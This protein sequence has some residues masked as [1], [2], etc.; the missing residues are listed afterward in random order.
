MK[1]L[2]LVLD[3]LADISHPELGWRTPLQA[4]ETPC[5][6][7]LA[8]EGCSA[9]MY[10]L[11]PGICPSSEVAHWAMFGYKPEEF[12]GRAYFHALAAGLPFATG[13]ALYMFNLVRVERRK[14]GTY[15]IDGEESSLAEACEALADELCGAAPEGL[16]V[17]YMGGIEF[18]AVVRGG[19]SRVM[20]TDPFIHAFPVEEMRAAPGWEEDEETAWTL[21][22]LREYAGRA[23]EIAAAWRDPCNC[24]LGVIEKW[25]S[26]AREVEAFE[27]RHGLR[28]AG[29]VSTPCFA[30][31][32]EAL[33]MRV[34]RKGA[35]EPEADLGAKLAAAEELLRDDREFVFVHTKH[36]DEAA[37]RGDPAAKAEVIEAMDRALAAGRLWDDPGILAVITADHSTP[38]THDGRVI[39]GGDA[40]PALF[41]GVTVR[42]DALERFDEVAAAGGGMGQLRGADLMP[43][44]LYL[45]RRARYFTG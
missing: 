13:D 39:H 23:E 34:V 14:G 37:H 18:L 25:P 42:R 1:A 21:A 27:E 24:A 44:V 22:L 11:R 36:A 35:P 29:V 2:L 31:M 10:P 16:E 3:G 28:A 20:P 32:C 15:V 19:S 6:D 8:S 5:L 38:T 40:V 26:R 43:L 12:P 4:A 45:A 9:L 7:R 41:H 30:G 33:S 17:F